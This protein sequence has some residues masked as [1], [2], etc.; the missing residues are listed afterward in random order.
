MRK[1]NTLILVLMILP[2]SIEAKERTI[3]LNV[4]GQPPLNTTEQTGFMDDVAKEAFR[5]IGIQLKTVRLPAE[6]GLVNANRGIV[7][8]EMSRVKGLDNLYKN[9]VRVPEKIMDWEFV[10]FSNSSISLQNGWSDLSAMSVSHINGWKIFEK[11]VPATAEIT[12]TSNANSLFNL[13]RRNR[14]DIILYE[15]WGGHYLLHEMKMNSVEICKPPLA[16]KEMFI[17]LHEKY[18]VLVPKLARALGTMKKDGSY[19]KLVNKHLMPYDDH[20]SSSHK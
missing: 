18:E 11:N 20:S 8:G 9:L 16:V 2:I 15:Q 6:R 17:Y 13:L 10:G 19:K 1:L 7:D 14:A 12:K 4:T 3:T 5:R